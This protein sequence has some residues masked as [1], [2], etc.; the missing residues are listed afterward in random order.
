MISDTL[1]TGIFQVMLIWRQVHSF[2]VSIFHIYLWKASWHD[3]CMMEI[4]NLEISRISYFG[5][6]DDLDQN[7]ESKM[8]LMEYHWWCWHQE[9][10]ES[11]S[12][13]SL[14]NCHPQN[15]DASWQVQELHLPEQPQHFSWTT[16]R[17]W[18][19]WSTE[20]TLLWRIFQMDWFPWQ[21]QL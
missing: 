9:R 19:D 17:T 16:D 14:Q 2:L 4:H 8:A 21:T 15:L 10:K 1:V 7:E 3:V 11:L 6:H 18:T 12:L 20:A 5:I 13:V